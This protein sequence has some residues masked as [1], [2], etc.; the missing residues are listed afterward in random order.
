MGQNMFGNFTVTTFSFFVITVHYVK[1]I[2]TP[3]VCKVSRQ[4]LTM[5]NQSFSPQVEA[6]DSCHVEWCAAIFIL[7]KS[8]TYLCTY[9]MHILYFHCV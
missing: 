1:I 7:H 6:M 2:L 4:G 5:V 8:M 9:T 3:T